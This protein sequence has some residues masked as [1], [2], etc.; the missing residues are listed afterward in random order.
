MFDFLIND[1]GVK[2][3]NLS[4]SPLPVSNN[5][6]PR[7]NNKELTH[8]SNALVKQFIV[9]LLIEGVKIG[10]FMR[11]SGMLFL[12]SIQKTQFQHLYLEIAPVQLSV[13]NRLVEHLKIFQVKP[14]I[15]Q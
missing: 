1:W 14:K 7:T 11:G 5:Q 9:S 6:E 15:T 8:V 4:Q 2:I 10:C 12:Q 3:G 13:Q